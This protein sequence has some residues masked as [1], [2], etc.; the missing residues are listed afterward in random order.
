MPNGAQA[1]IHAHT[2]THIHTHH[3]GVHFACILVEKFA[4]APPLPMPH[5]LQAA[6]LLLFLLTELP[7]YRGNGKPCLSPADAARMRSCY[8]AVKMRQAACMAE[9]SLS[10]CAG[11]EADR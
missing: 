4:C 8:A 2:H 5:P 10:A 11:C 9:L 6:D 1:H 7:A 3:P